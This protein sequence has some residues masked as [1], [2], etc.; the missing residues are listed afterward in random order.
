[1]FPMHIYVVPEIMS[2]VRFPVGHNGDPDIR[3][4]SPE[5]TVNGI[6]V[7]STNGVD[8]AIIGVNDE[9]VSTDAFL[10]LPCKDF[11]SADGRYNTN[12]YKYFVFST[13][14][15]STT[16][17]FNSRFL[18]IPCTSRPDISY[19]LPGA[20]SSTPVP[21]LDQYETF[22]VQHSDDLTGTV[23]TSNAPLAVFVGH[24]CGQV[25]SDIIACDHLVEQ[26][27]PHATFG[28]TFFALP[29]ALRESGDIFRVGSVVDDNEVVITC[30]KRASTGVVTVNTLS[31]VTIN[32][33]DYYEFRTLARSDQIDLSSADYRR[34]FCCIETSKPAIVMQYSLGHSADLVNLAGVAGQQGDPAMS[35]V[36]PVTQYRNNFLLTTADQVRASSFRGFIGWA[37]SA[38]FF[39]LE[40]SDQN[41][42]LIAK[43][44]T[45]FLPPMRHELGSQEYVPIHCQSGE[46]CGY[47]AFSLL[48]P[49]TA[50]VRYTSEREPNAAV[51][52]SVYGVQRETSFAYPAGYECEPIGRE[53]YN[54]HLKPRS[55]RQ[56]FSSSVLQISTVSF[57]LVSC[58]LMFWVL[59][60]STLLCQNY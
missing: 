39:N 2:V 3:V 6:H 22:I 59:R 29:F 13:S 33:G 1:M 12:Q 45:T 21:L 26:V 16:L 30:T 41:N 36:P 7:F 4:T 53:Y 50:T 11:R 15:E 32:E 49:G 10:A 28:T 56:F 40:T 8:I 27:P 54:K 34:D 57:A 42:F 55:L 58:R 9:S 14:A 44:D 20:D 19:R 35:L 47:G 18:I 51:Y 17:N 46:V 5:Q 60:F 48:V 24:E 25:P 52:V 38:E 43:D 37:L 23:I 31:A